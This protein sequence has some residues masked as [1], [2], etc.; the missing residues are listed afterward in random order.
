VQLPSIY[1][2]H[3]DHDIALVRI[4]A[5]QE[6]THTELLEKLG[7]LLAHGGIQGLLLDLRQNPGGLV[8][9]AVAVADEFLGS[10]LLFFTRQRTKVT[11]RVETTSRGHFEE[12]PMVTLVDA[13]SASAAEILAG[14]LKDRHRSKLVGTRTFGKGTVQTI[15]DLPE[16]AGLRL[17]AMRYYTPAGIGIQASGVQPDEVVD[18]TEPE[19]ADALRES[20]LPN[21]LASE[22]S[23]TPSNS[24]TADPNTL[25]VER[26]CE[27]PTPVL[28]IAERIARLPPSP[29]ASD[30]IALARGYRLLL[31]L[32]SSQPR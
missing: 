22:V 3:L 2:R 23:T 30:D 26:T 6:G 19:R 28:S 27:K 12:V 1:V 14:A 10:G 21:H 32:L 29:T 13:G 25:P 9:E 17:T 20:D 31:S 24:K 16:G 18:D 4:V 11:E 8:S 7:S 15:V 5:F